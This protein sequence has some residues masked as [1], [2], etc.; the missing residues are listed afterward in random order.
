MRDGLVQGYEA[1]IEQVVLP[2]PN[3]RHVLA[4]AIV[5][6]ANV[7][8]TFNLKDFSEHILRQYGTQAQ[9]P[10]LFISGLL[11][12]SP[13]IVC[14]AVRRHRVSLKNPPKSVGEY[15]A[16]LREQGLSKTAE[17]LHNFVDTI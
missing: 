1:L 14:K 13:E 6:N 9:H 11:K 16:T 7:I 12:K 5:A 2:D 10:D 8:V 3:D 4:A 15:V 17:A